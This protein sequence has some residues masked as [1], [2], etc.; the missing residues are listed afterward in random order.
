MKIHDS[1]HSI[2]SNIHAQKLPASSENKSGPIASKLNS[3]LTSVETSSTENLKSQLNVSE[4]RDALVQEI[5]VKYQ[6]GEYLTQ[7]AAVETA[8]AILNL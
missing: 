1:G 6:A 3:S 5:K 8:D 2:P 7:K 4:V